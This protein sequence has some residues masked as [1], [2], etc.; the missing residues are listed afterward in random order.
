MEKHINQIREGWHTFGSNAYVQE[1]IRRVQKGITYIWLAV[2][3][4]PGWVLMSFLLIYSSLW[5]IY[6]IAAQKD[7][8][9][10]IDIIT[11]NEDLQLAIAVSVLTFGVILAMAR[12]RYLLTIGALLVIVYTGYLSLGTVRGDIN[13]GGWRGVVYLIAAAGGVLIASYSSWLYTRQSEDLVEQKAE[14][15][16][17]SEV[18]RQVN[19]ENTRLKS[20]IE[21]LQKMLEQASGTRKLDSQPN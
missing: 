5:D 8:T 3:M 19:D 14:T 16:A 10:G 12:D 17:V 7:I 15:R 13:I 20:Q 9:T 21:N 6:V 1:G 18:A 4:I 11:T 2:G